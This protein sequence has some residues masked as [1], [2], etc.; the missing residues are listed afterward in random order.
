MGPFTKTKERVQKIKEKADLRCIYQNELDKTCFQH[1]MTYGDFKDFPRTTAADK[2]LHN[3][4]FNIAKNPKY[5]V[6]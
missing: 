3:E 6:Y 4:A 1:N 2:V 5:H